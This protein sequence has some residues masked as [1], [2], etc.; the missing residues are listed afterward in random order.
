[1]KRSLTILV[2][3]ALLVTAIPQG[4][5][6]KAKPKLSRSKISIE[7]GKSK[8]LKVSGVKK[9]KWSTSKSKIVSL[10]AKKSKSVK[11]VAKKK[12]KAV[13]SA[14]YTEAGKAK[15]LTCKVTVKS[16]IEDNNTHKN[17]SDNNQTA[18]TQTQP[19]QPEAS[20]QADTGTPTPVPTPMPSPSVVSESGKWAY[21]P[22]EDDTLLKE[23]EKIFGNVGTCLT[24]SGM[25]G[26]QELQDK[27]TMEFVRKNY[28]SFT[29]ENE[30]KPSYLLAD[31]AASF[32][33]PPFNQLM[34]VSEAESKG[35]VVPSGYNETWVP[36][37]NYDRLDAILK[38]AAEN[39]IR[40]RAHTLIWHSQTPT[41]F[42]RKNYRTDGEFV[43]PEVMDQRV[44]Y[45]VTN[46]V[47]HV[48]DSE[49]R[50]V[51]YTWDI[52]NEYFHQ[53][54]DNSARNWS[55]VYDI[56]KGGNALSTTPSF[57][58]L[59]FKAAY[60]VLAQYGLEES[61][62]LLYNDYNT[63]QVSDEI[64][65]MINYVNSA[66]EINPEG[67]KICA[68]VGMQ[69]HLDTKW[70]TVEEQL[71]TVQKFLDAGFEVQITELDII[72]NLNLSEDGHCDY[73]YDF[74]KG[75]VD[76]RKNGA[77]ITGVT[78]WGLSDSVSWRFGQSALLYGSGIK[79]PKKALYAVYAA[80]QSILFD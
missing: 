51:V 54:S 44:I 73:W 74:M 52:A 39:G 12:G 57:V 13:V 64:V 69:S 24:Y 47:K 27:E 50:D 3:A 4:T 15:K 65:A 20:A 53:L 75:L 6:A 68:G 60:D 55:Q 5:D 70:P 56:V 18:A 30:M 25:G 9:V 11:L 72:N 76:K 2:A 29:L 1:M 36:S 10:A 37:I 80:A 35:Y 14:K 79:D 22:V 40:M 66:D 59:A 26:K 62:S 7:A 78:F 16:K 17:E 34:S 23:Y 48:C 41:E 42:F 19:I 63:S 21:I 43:A 45:F 49:Y 32:W 33:N 46:V 31:S 61:V 67:K 8:K 28:N 58:K 38:V 77:A 71:G